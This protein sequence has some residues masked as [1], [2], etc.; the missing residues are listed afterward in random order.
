MGESW[1][2]I[3]RSFFLEGAGGERGWGGGGRSGFLEIEGDKERDGG[4]GRK[5][6]WNR[7]R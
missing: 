2:G 3:R 4:L 5:D 7:L 6:G 1:L